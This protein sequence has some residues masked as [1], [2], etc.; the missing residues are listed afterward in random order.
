MYWDD[1]VFFVESYKRKQKRYHC[2]KKLLKIE[3]KK[4]LKFTFVVIDLSET[5]C[6]NIYDDGEIEKIFQMNSDVSNKHNQGGQSAQRFERNREQQIVKYY[7]RINDK[8]K[9]LK[10]EII[11]GVNFVYKSKLKRYLASEVMNK[12][13]RFETIEYGGVT[14]AH[15]FRNMKI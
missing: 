12:I 15:Q 4:E 10:N 11:I 5:Y 13:I 7:K 14:G 6:A 8:L 1:E 2:G 3:K 9:T